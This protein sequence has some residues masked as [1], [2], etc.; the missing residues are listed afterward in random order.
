[1]FGDEYQERDCVFTWQDGYT[2][3]PDYVTK[4]FKK[5]VARSK[6]LSSEITFRDLRKSCV[7]MM[8]EDDYSIKEI[9]KWVGYAEVTM[10]VYTKIKES[11][12]TYIGE[13]MSEKFKQAI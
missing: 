8:V 3:S 4:A 10:N 12:K 9:Q 5:I 13:S 7:S 6:N 1:M 2:I 11:R